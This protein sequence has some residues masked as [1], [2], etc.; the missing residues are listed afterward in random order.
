MVSSWYEY[1]CKLSI[2]TRKSDQWITT[3]WAKCLLL[4]LIYCTSKFV[5]ICKKWTLNAGTKTNRLTIYWLFWFFIRK[6]AQL[7][8]H[9]ESSGIYF[10]L[11]NH[12]MLFT[13]VNSNINNAKMQNLVLVNPKCVTYMQPIHPALKRC[14]FKRSHHSD[15]ILAFHSISVRSCPKTAT[16]VDWLSNKMINDWLNNW[17]I[18]CLIGWLVGWLIDW[19]IDW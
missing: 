1:W 17:L 9:S 10:S 16:N 18:D 6:I 12:Q 8:C 19:L 3:W 15:I 11:C 13:M 4:I 5:V 2:Y 7:N 14:R